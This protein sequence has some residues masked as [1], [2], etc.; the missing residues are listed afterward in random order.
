MIL[1]IPE[2]S[3][4]FPYFLQCKSEFGNNK[5]VV[6]DLSHSQLP[7]LHIENSKDSIRKLLELV[8]EFSKVTGYKINTQKSLA[9]Q[10]TN[11]EKSEKAIK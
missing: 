2:W 5:N 10:Y 11:N 3:R 1:V 4:G 9:F 8:S 7:I 6:H